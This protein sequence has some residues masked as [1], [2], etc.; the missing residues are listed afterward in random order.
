LPLLLLLPLPLPLPLPVLRRHPEPKAKDP[1][2]GTCR[3]PA[4][5]PIHAASPHGWVNTHKRQDKQSGAISNIQRWMANTG[6]WTAVSASPTTQKLRSGLYPAVGWLLHVLSVAFTHPVLRVLQY[7]RPTFAYGDTNRFT[8]FLLI[9]WKHLS[10]PHVANVLGRK[11]DGQRSRRADT[12][13]VRSY[14]SVAV[15]L[16]DLEINDRD[17]WMTRVKLSRGLSAGGR[18]LVTVNLSLSLISG[19]R[20]RIDGNPCTF[21]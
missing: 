2:I 7:Q 18:S 4:G 15:P 8:C 3:C 6:S 19:V 17:V 12:V 11:A 20:L 1:R 13:C 21:C 16:D 10:L 5:C 9:F 14:N